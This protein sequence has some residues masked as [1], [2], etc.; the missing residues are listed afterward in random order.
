MKETQTQ[1]QNLNDAGPPRRRR[2]WALWLAPLVIIFLVLWGI[3]PRIQARRELREDT[4]RNAATAVVAEKPQKGQPAQ[5][6]QL[7]GNIRAFMD[8]PIYARTN[9]YLRHWYADIGTHVR[10]G[11]LLAEVETPE[12][13][14]QLAQAR[15]DLA[16]AQANAALSQTT[17]ARYQGLLQSD[18]V[19]KQDTDTAVASAR[20]QSA[21]VVSAQANVRRLGELQ[22]FQ[23]IEAPFDG[24][25]TARNTDVGQLINSGAGAP[26]LE[27]FHIAAVNTL[28]VFVNLPE[29]YTSDIKVGMPATLTVAAI[30]GRSFTGTLVRTAN[31]IDP[32]SRTLLVEVDVDNRQGQLLPGSYAEVQF[33][34]KSTSPTLMVPVS[35]LL[36][37]A[38]GLRIAIVGPDNR[39]KLV[40]VTVG[41][42]YGTRIEVLSGIGP[43]DLVIDSPPDSLLDGEEVRVVQRQTQPSH[44]EN[45][46]GPAPQ[47]LTPNIPPAQAPK[48]QTGDGTK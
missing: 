29:T 2:R 37:R 6:V 1:G 42:D 40:P 46:K 48:A 20:A 25:I 32:A 28:R 36:F 3:L 23:R 11:Q 35:A 38:E 14:Q 39:A 45:G 34:L 18:S 26:E 13:D 30:K 17:A 10:K 43:N 8:A 15:A 44:A 9:G 19:S 21:A 22:G 5:E 4:S 12:A 24:V 16:V 31:A 7:P 33:H 47:R 27:L 41:R